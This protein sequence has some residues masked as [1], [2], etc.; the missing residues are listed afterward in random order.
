MTRQRRT[1]LPITGLARLVLA[2]A[3]AV[4]A[5]AVWSAPEVQAQATRT[6]VSGVGDDVNPCSRTAPC[7]TFAGA[8]SKTAAGGEIDCLDPGGFGAVTITKSI[9]IDCT[10][11]FGSILASGV[12]GVNVNDSASGAPRTIKV[13]LRGL[14]INGAGGGLIGV[15]FTSG[16]VVTIEDTV[17]FGFNAGSG[18]GVFASG[19]NLAGA[20]QQLAIRNVVVR[21]NGQGIAGGGGVVVG[22]VFPAAPSAGV[23][24][25]TLHNVD[26]V[27]N[28]IGLRVSASSD[29]TTKSSN[30]SHNTSFNVLAFTSGGSAIV[31]AEDT[32]FSESIAGTG[33]HSEGSGAIIRMSRCTIT[34]NNIG[35]ASVNTGAILSAGNNL[36]QGNFGGNGAFTGVAPLS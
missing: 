4:V 19:N 22:A 1:G 13:H 17:I 8:I 14:S 10:G 21:D 23:I 18:R 9:T 29:V 15:N 24:R 20:F 2:I 27:R 33:A 5:V 30:I 34:A 31:N 35:L 25:A 26:A 36:N 7:K 11:T 16:A 32:V 28:N 6:W 12:N 3:I